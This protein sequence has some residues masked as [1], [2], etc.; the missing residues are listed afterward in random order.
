M[1][2]ENVVEL[3]TAHSPPEHTPREIDPA[4]WR[5]YEANVAEILA[6]FGLE[7]DT[8]GTRDTPER[9]LRAL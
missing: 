4:D 7:L 3:R 1:S 9:F 5:R 8:P 2:N 6:A